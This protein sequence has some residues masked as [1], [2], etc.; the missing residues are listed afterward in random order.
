[1]PLCATKLC[2]I[3]CGN[4]GLAS[5]YSALYYMNSTS[6]YALATS[7]MHSDKGTVLMDIEIPR[8]DWL[9]RLRY[10]RRWFIDSRTAVTERMKMHGRDYILSARYS[11]QRMHAML[12]FTLATVL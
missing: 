10:D 11:A 5:G 2:A 12:S 8:T 9:E 1:M 4:T 7:A 6:Q 3:P